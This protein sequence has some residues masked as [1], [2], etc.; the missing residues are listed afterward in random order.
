MCSYFCCSPFTVFMENYIN[1]LGTWNS[2]A[3]YSSLFFSLFRLSSGRKSINFQVSARKTI[4]KWNSIAMP[5]AR[6]I[7]FFSF[8][9]AN[10]I[11][12]TTFAWLPFY[13]NSRFCFR[14]LVW[15][16]KEVKCWIHVWNMCWN[17]DAAWNLIS[18]LNAME[19][20]IEC[21]LKCSKRKW[22]FKHQFSIENARPSPL[23]WSFGCC[24]TEYTLSAHSLESVYILWAPS[25]FY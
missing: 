6:R 11:K 24:P 25:K 12:I 22:K 8:F 21:H 13:L 2:F 4:E 14:L 19:I 16:K 5:M 18:W 20:S 23:H 1:I 15:I 10:L 7:S 9:M 17:V 3:L